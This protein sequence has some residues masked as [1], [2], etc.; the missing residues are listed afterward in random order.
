MT[1]VESWHLLCIFFVL[2]LV[3]A[4]VKV[5]VTVCVLRY[6]GDSNLSE[7]RC[8]VRCVV[9]ASVETII[10]VGVL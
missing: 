9:V 4:S 8:L 5:V 10:A 6:D 3:V 7:P 1:K 2:V